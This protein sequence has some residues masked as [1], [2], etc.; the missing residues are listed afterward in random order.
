MKS[1]QFSEG[2]VE[3][4]GCGSS[5]SINHG[6]AEMVVDAHP[7]SFLAGQTECVE[8]DDYVWAA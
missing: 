6:H 7:Q 5:W 3:C 4:S 8:A 2:L 1:L